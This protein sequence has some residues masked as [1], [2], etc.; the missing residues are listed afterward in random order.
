MFYFSTDL[1]PNY[2]RVF[3][4]VMRRKIYGTCKYVTCKFIIVSLTVENSVS[5]LV[6]TKVGWRAKEKEESLKK[7]FRHC[8]RGQNFSHGY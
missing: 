4:E 2:F 7:N 8:R 3:F 6:I 1:S 5:D